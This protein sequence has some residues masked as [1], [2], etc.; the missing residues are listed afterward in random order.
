MLSAIRKNEEFSRKLT[1][2]KMNNRFIHAMCQTLEDSKAETIKADNSRYA[3]CVMCSFKFMN[4]RT[5]F[6]IVNKE[7]YYY[8]LKMS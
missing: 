7:I 8:Y 2:C 1:I 5:I 4:V 6:N 3:I